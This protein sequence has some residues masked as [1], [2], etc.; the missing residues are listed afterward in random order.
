MGYKDKPPRKVCQSGFS[1][2][3]PVFHIACNASAANVGL[4][5]Q[6][7][8]LFPGSIR[9]GWSLTLRDLCEISWDLRAPG[10][11]DTR[12]ATTTGT[13]LELTWDPQ[14][15][16]AGRMCWMTVSA[17]VPGLMAVSWDWPLSGYCTRPH[18]IRSHHDQ[19]FI[20]THYNSHRSFP[21]WQDKDTRIYE[22]YH[23]QEPYNTNQCYV[24]N[25]L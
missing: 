2:E 7:C 15:P 5:S 11:T 3:W 20:T 22:K 14:I 9:K 6:A 13:D 10:S 24:K 19:Y 25:S 12:E 18:Y 21:D 8:L 16:D 1:C 4:W 17:T 23:L